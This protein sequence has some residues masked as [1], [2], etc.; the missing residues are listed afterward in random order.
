MREVP[1]EKNVD[2]K[3]PEINILKTVTK[4]TKE[5]ADKQS[6]W[7]DKQCLYTLSTSLGCSR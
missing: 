2:L 5:G 6:D 7:I 1:C 3:C 4:I